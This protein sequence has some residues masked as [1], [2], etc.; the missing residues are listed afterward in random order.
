MGLLF[1]PIAP[2]P[3][4]ATSSEE[5]MRSAALEVDGAIC[6]W[7]STSLTPLIFS[8]FA[9]RS[10]LSFS[11]GT[12]PRNVTLP[13]SVSKCTFLADAESEESVLSVWWIF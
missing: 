11:V 7:L 8:T 5:P 2:L 3:L 13:L 4:D 1:D 10:F 9:S 6:N 12:V